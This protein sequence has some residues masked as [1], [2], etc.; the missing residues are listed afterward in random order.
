MNSRRRD[1][2]GSPVGFD[3]LQ[4]V[5]ARLKANVEFQRMMT[6]LAVRA[7]A[8]RDL[9]ELLPRICEDVAA[10]FV[11]PLVLVSRFQ[12]P[13]TLVIVAS[14]QSA[15]KLPMGIS[16]HEAGFLSGQAVRERRTVY[17]N[18]LTGQLSDRLL[19]VVHHAVESVIAAPIIVDG[20]VLGSI[21][22]GSD[23]RDR[24]DDGDLERI[25]GVAYVVGNA[26]V[27][28]QVYEREH[29]LAQRLK[30]L[31]S[32]RSAFLHVMAHELRTPLGQVLGFVDLL[33]DESAGLTSLGRRYLAN[34]R[35][36]GANLDNVVRR[37]LDVLDLFGSDVQLSLAPLNLSDLIVGITS[38]HRAAAARKQ[39]TLEVSRNS[40]VTVVAGDGRRLRQALDILF[41]NAVKFV[42]NGGSI[43]FAVES[44]E[45][46]IQLTL[47]NSGPSVPP[48]LAEQ[49]F[50]HGLIEN[51]LTRLHGGAGLSLLLARRIAELHG[52]SL[53]L[54]P[55]EAGARFVLRLPATPGVGNAAD[56]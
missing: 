56:G 50:T 24:F 1:S 2:S 33:G 18:C 48:E 14:T 21:G 25:T 38:T 44:S 9:A 22:L 45:E 6:A 39:A 42:P 37:A 54:D 7:T 13:D 11:V 8:T 55:S 40:S 10:A 19:S 16:V 28:A 5:E 47:W 23:E 12:E 53:V 43:T 26:L 27:N 36:A 34:V 15:I 31:E 51:S 35:E 41:D 4:E 30:A 52:G 29:L 3:A 49:I 17:R 32:W 46:S 20:T